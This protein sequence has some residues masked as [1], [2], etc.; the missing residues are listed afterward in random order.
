MSKLEN[1]EK[2]YS[3]KEMLTVTGKSLAGVAMVGAIPAILTG[4]GSKAAAVELPA[5]EVLEYEYMEKSEDAPQ[6]PYTYQKLDMTTAW[7]RG[8][9]GYYN[10]GGC[11]RGVADA[12]IGE[13]GDQ[14]GYP[15]NQIP[16][17]MFAN[18]TT[19]YGIGSL[20]GALGGAV[21]A[22]GLVCNDDDAKAVTKELFDWYQKQEFPLHQPNAEMPTTVANSVNCADSVS[23]FMEAAGVD[24][25]D[26]L[27]KERC[28]CVTGDVALK[29]VELL[30]NFYNL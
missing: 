11:C 25:K 19:G 2:L 16:V 6:Y 10:K 8:H 9:A 30:N 14:A 21:A 23:K 27:R 13:L 17:D 22:I 4:C 15:F 7:E 24:M 5:K 28:A 26:P 12:I 1:K 3:R 18:G 29:T 20:C